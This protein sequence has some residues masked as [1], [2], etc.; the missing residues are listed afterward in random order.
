MGGVFNSDAAGGL[1]TNETTI[2]DELKKAGY[3]TQAIG[4]VRY[5]RS[6]NNPYTEMP[7]ARPFGTYTPRWSCFVLSPAVASRPET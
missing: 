2:A 4:K 5:H 7:A 1:P 3:A 6:R